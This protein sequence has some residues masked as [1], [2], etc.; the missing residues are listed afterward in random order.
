MTGRSDR[1][2]QFFEQSRKAAD[3]VRGVRESGRLGEP[4]YTEEQRAD[5]RAFMARAERQGVAIRRV[6]RVASGEPLALS[7]S[8]AAERPDTPGAAV[9]LAK[10][11]VPLSL[12]HRAMTDLLRGLPVTLDVPAV[13]DLGALVAELA[14][15]GVRAT[16]AA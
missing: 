5:M 16:A 7:L 2:K 9:A 11:H 8:V 10:R 15:C 3:L 4:R 13:E 6:A 1:E 14:A 12:A